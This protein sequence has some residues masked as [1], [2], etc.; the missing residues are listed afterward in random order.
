M[1][2]PPVCCFISGIGCLVLLEE[3]HQRFYA[4]F[5][6]GAVGGSPQAAH[7][8]V[9]LKIFKARRF[10]GRHHSQYGQRPQVIFLSVFPLFL[11]IFWTVIHNCEM[12]NA[13]DDFNKVTPDNF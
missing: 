13:V 10:G 7:R 5:G 8:L 3:L 2:R 6:H 1:K 12:K 11:C 4:L 9:A